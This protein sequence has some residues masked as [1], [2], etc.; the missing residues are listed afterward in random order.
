[1]ASRNLLTLRAELDE[2]TKE[3]Q[4]LQKE[5][6]Q[7]TQHTINQLSLSSHEKCH[8]NTVNDNNAISRL[9]HA[10]SSLRGNN[11][12]LSSA[13]LQ[14]L[15]SRLVASQTSQRE[16]GLETQCSV[17]QKGLDGSTCLVDKQP[18]KTLLNDYSSLFINA[19][20]RPEEIDSTQRHHQHF[21]SQSINELNL[22]VQELIK[23]NA[24]MDIRCN[25][26]KK[27]EEGNRQLQGRIQELETANGVQEEMLKQAH[28]YIDI[29][30]EMLQKRDHVH[31]DIQGAIL[32]YINSSGKEISPNC[33]LSNLGTFVVEMCQE[34]ADEV[35]S[36][37]T[38]L[39]TTEDQTDVLK[40]E[41]GDKENNLKQCQERCDH[42]VKKHEQEMAAMSHEMNTATNHAKTMQD[43]LETL[44]QQNTKHEEHIANLESVVSELRSELKSCKKT[45]KD[46]VEE[47]KKQLLIANNALEKAQNEHTQLSQDFGKQLQELKH[48]Q[49]ALKVCENQ[50]HLEREHNRQLQEQ[51]NVSKFTNDH[52]RRELIERSM[53]V[54]RLQLM[55]TMVKEESQQKEE[56]KL[57]T[58]Q[59]KT[60]NLNLRTCQLES[61]KATLQNM[62]EE[63]KAKSQSLK[64]SE[65][66]INES[67]VSL[68]EKDKALKNAVE[69]LR[70]LRLYAEAKKKELQQ[71]KATSDQMSEMLEDTET[72]KQLLMEKD[73]MIMTL[74][75]QIQTLTRVVGQQNQ[76]VGSLEAEKSQLL[77]EASLMNAVI[78]DS[79]V[80]A[81]KK[82]I[83]IHELEEMCRLLNMEK[84]KLTNECIEKTCA[85]NKLKKERKDILA[86]LRET[87]NELAC[88]SEDYE[89]MERNN[90]NRTEGS[91]NATA[92]LKM[93]LKAAVAELAQTKNTLKT[94]EDCDGHAI[95]IATRMQKKITA[96]RKHIDALQSR[97]QFLEEALSNTTKEKRHLKLEK[98]KLL[99]ECANQAD[100][101]NKLCDA[102][103]MLK[104]ENKALKTNIVNTEA[105][106]DKT[107][108]QLSECQAVIQRLEQEITVL[109]LQHTLDL[110][111]LR[112]P[113]SNQILV[114]PRHEIASE[115]FL[116][117][118]DVPVHEYDS[119]IKSCP[120]VFMFT[121]PS[122]NFNIVEP[123]EKAINLSDCL[124]CAPFKDEGPL[125]LTS[126][127]YTSS[128]KENYKNHEIQPRSP[129]YSLL[130]APTSHTDIFETLN[131]N[132]FLETIYSDNFEHGEQCKELTNS[133]CQILQ[134]RL[135]CLQTI[136]EDLQ[137]KNKGVLILSVYKR[138]VS[139]SLSVWRGLSMATMTGFGAGVGWASSEVLSTGPSPN[140]LVKYIQFGD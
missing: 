100:E 64:N 31:Q 21:V 39:H 68:A 4:K 27:Q 79:M 90:E 17:M 103:E 66:N 49:E 15:K 104:S 139:E 112:G 127:C 73:N 33:D 129:V 38:K 89:T 48:L 53:E 135:E 69:E 88:L 56:E 80:V 7:A 109:K 20:K 59:D 134:H 93:Q 65:K 126:P 23:K 3:I 136:A 132:H 37:K 19:Q 106:L 22:K 54:E 36:L 108:L 75:D 18:V 107:L 122:V 50:V 81:E 24:E 51:A 130:T 131:R 105:T 110:K 2:Q 84:S 87:Q 55:V 29:L 72:L 117:P 115:S 67:K 101:K 42:F 61:M 32:T 138:L 34:L 5:V 43:Q 76:K 1:M 13:P 52:L 99:Q 116:Q 102:V 6:E 82:D 133:T 35:S 25:E 70:K 40:K 62:T 16:G 118:C 119:P 58:I 11:N 8:K 125:K 86:E 12:V 124:R 30:K 121:Q 111:E 74:R 45:S 60:A 96:K 94:V 46:K 78:Q 26:S 9:S 137:M 77:D 71:L 91:E 41:L 10:S 92:I 44:Q 128:L 47:L 95:K 120:K 83:K 113:F 85:S 14:I 98:A 97:I 57:K 63:L 114:K 140:K 28:A 123:S